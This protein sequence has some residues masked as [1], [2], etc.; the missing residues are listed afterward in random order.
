M[1]TVRSGARSNATAGLFHFT[2]AALARALITRCISRPRP[3]SGEVHNDGSAVPA[4][5][6]LE[7]G[8]RAHLAR[9]REQATNRASWS[10][11][12][13]RMTRYGISSITRLKRT[14]AIIF[15]GRSMRE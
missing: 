13:S 1:E 8:E 7:H 15:H 14:S 9:H 5:E 2:A 10:L 11:L 12:E 6:P 4:L 3:L